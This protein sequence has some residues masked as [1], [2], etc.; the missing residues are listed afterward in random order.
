M[1]K[2]LVCALVLTAPS[3][4]AKAAN[5]WQPR[6]KPTPYKRV[7]SNPR[8]PGQP[9]RTMAQAIGYM[10]NGPQFHKDVMELLPL[11]LAPEVRTSEWPGITQELWHWVNLAAEH[12][13]MNGGCPQCSGSCKVAPEL[14]RHIEFV[15]IPYGT[16]Y[17]ALT[18]GRDGKVSFNRVFVGEA[19]AYR[20]WLRNRSVYIDLIAR[21]HNTGLGQKEVWE[22]STAVMPPIR[23]KANANAQAR[24]QANTGDVVFNT[25]APQPVIGYVVPPLAMRDTR[26]YNAGSLS[27]WPKLETRVRIN[28]T[29][30][31]PGVISPGGG[32]NQGQV[33]II[34]GPNQGQT[35]VQTPVSGAGNQVQGPVLP[36]NQTQQGPV[37]QGQGLQQQ[38]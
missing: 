23:A 19:H 22:I 31:T 18:E 28:Q 34:V 5:R 10:Q 12:K 35:P 30:P 1:K 11:G 16:Q 37:Y 20:V 13:Y 33:P 6:E 21:C 27:W 36:G 38:R 14:M 7:G 26:G 25:Y 4:G 32:G 15:D 29:F 24:A 9:I 3:I 8:V 2:L 17:L